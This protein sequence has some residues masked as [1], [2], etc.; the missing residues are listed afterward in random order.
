[1]TTLTLNNSPIKRDFNNSEALNVVIDHLFEKEIQKENVLVNIRIDGQTIPFEEG[2]DVGQEKLSAFN[3]IDFEVQ[4]SVELAF[5]ALD[6]CNDYIDILNSKITELT[7]LYQAGSNENASVLF[8]ETIDI[9]DLFIQLFSK[10]NSTLGRNLGEDKV[11]KKD[12]QNLE[13]HLL[14]ILKALI[15][16]KE[17]GD[18]IMLCDLLEYE[19]IDNL[20][21]WKIKVVPQL[22]ALKK[23]QEP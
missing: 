1:M 15:P 5:E 20:T 6:S 16:A 11:D 19:L 17:K 8:N 7:R 21:Q 4:T 2:F 22:K 3:N 10:I 23:P 18:I 14:S 9:L 12:I 13:I